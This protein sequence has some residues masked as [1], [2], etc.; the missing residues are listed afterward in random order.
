MS[1]KSIMPSV[2]WLVLF[3]TFP[4]SGQAPAPIPPADQPPAPGQ[5]KLTGDD[6]K[7]VKQLIDETNTAVK[8]DRW[9]EAIARAEDLLTLRKR[10]QGP[11]HFETKAST[12]RPSSPTRRPSRSGGAFSQMTTQ[13]C[14]GLRQPRDQ[15]RRPGEPHPGATTLREGGR[16]LRPVAR[17]AP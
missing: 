14:H 3:V 11:K 9:D 15:S 10:I 16:S 7:R 8:A 4:V 17:H 13:H 5:R 2:A 1:S 6:E 12:P